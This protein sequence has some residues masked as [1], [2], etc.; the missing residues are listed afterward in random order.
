MSSAPRALLR[1]SKLLLQTTAAQ[2]QALLQSYAADRRLTPTKQLHAHATVAGHFSSVQL[3]SA[4]ATTYASCDFAPYSRK[5]FDELPERSLFLYNLVVRV[6][7]K[8]GAL[9]DAVKVF[10]EMLERGGECKPDHFT[11]PF[12][13]KACGEMGWV[14][15]GGGAHGRLCRDGFC[16]GVYVQNALMAMYLNWGCVEEARK[17]FDAMVEKSVSSWNTIISGYFRHGC[18]EQALVVYDQ[19]VNSGFEPDSATVVSVLP[20]CGVLEKLDVGRGVHEVVKEKGLGGDLVVRN[21]L[22]DMYLKCCSVADARLVF[23]DME[24]KD[25]ITWSSM[26]NGYNLNGD[27]RNALVLC[28][29]MQVEGVVPNSVTITSLLSACGNSR[30]LRD[31]KCLHG[32]AMRRN[33]ATETIIES[34]LIDMYAKCN[35]VDLSFQ[36]LKNMPNKK[37]V[38]WNALLSGCVQNG[39]A[40][41]AIVNFKYMLREA[42]CPDCA[43]FLS[44]LPAYAALADSQQGVNIHGYLL[45]CGLLLKSEVATGLVD[46]YTKSGRLDYAQRVFLSIA[47]EDKDI[48]SWSAIIAGCGKH[49]HGETAISLFDQMVSSGV[50]PNEITFTAALHACSHAG[51]VDKGLSLFKFLAEECRTTPRMDHYACVVDMLGRAGR[52]DEAYK[53]ITKMPYTANHSVW[54]A[55]L[56]ACVI[57]EDVEIGEAAASKL[58]QLEP[59][60]TGNSVLLAKLYASVGRWKDAERVR[61]MVNEIGL[62]KAPAQSLI[63]VRC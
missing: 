6:M 29:L 26:I 10:V 34:S 60:N 21:A 61:G 31:G 38:A 47:D 4:F 59:E 18:A 3:R 23:D 36:V 2:C 15:M 63:E 42:I 54:G 32:W 41:E 44:L 62:R 14:G 49:G 50:K 39:L 51:L 9:V 19:M 24:M 48:V 40:R 45:K 13:L 22:I 1:K 58:F 35:R 12:V 17:V 43:T 56:G 25:V 53:M 30:S 28:R 8:N 7:V 27:A 5:L 46:I 55:L 20:A 16:W 52:L 37:A 33:L 57:H 11:Y